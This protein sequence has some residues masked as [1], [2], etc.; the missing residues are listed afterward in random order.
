MDI[1][2]Q[3]YR[4]VDDDGQRCY[5]PIER[6]RSAFQCG[7]GDHIAIQGVKGS[8]WHH[9]IVEDVDTKK[10]IIHVLEYTNT[11]TEFFEDN[12]GSPRKP[13]IAKVRRG[14]YSGSE[15]GLYLIKHEKCLPADTVISKAKERL[16][17]NSY[18]P[19]ENNC[20]HF[21]MCCKT[22]MSLSQQVKDAKQ[23]GLR[24]TAKSAVVSVA[25]NI[26]L[27][28]GGKIKKA[29]G[30]T[31]T[32]QVDTQTA[33]K[34]GQGI[35]ETSAETDLKQVDTQSVLQRGQDMIQRGQN[36]VESGEALIQMGQDISECFQD[37]TPV[38]GFIAGAACAG[39]VEFAF[40]S[41]DLHSLREDLNAGKISKKQ[42]KDAFGK[43]IAGGVGS[44]TGCTTGAVV[45]QILLPVPFV[46]AFVGGFAGALAGRFCG[47]RLWDAK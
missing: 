31:A 37:M 46:G 6:V 14:E 36:I 44:V 7:K 4:Y 19:L 32:K 1:N 5:V 20:E 23:T 39:S 16:G 17:E 21:A 2:I 38:A 41:Y 43:Q 34:G 27:K 11:A 12:F 3:S 24:E 26:V 18:H 13:G 33:S 25:T 8:Y 22:G 28:R 10:N 42:Y 47:N 9:A 45:G 29:G 40:A 30:Q 35:M 15:Y